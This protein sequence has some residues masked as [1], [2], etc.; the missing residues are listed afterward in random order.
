M[1]GLN[2]LREMKLKIVES[3]FES[4]SFKKEIVEVELKSFH[5]IEKTYRETFGDL[6]AIPHKYRKDSKE[7]EISCV[8]VTAN[9][10]ICRLS[11]KFADI[12]QKIKELDN[13]RIDLH[14]KLLK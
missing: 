1:F 11:K 10:H 9:M 2:L 5:N 3:Q 6:P 13:K 4:L 7:Y 8:L 12:E 14:E